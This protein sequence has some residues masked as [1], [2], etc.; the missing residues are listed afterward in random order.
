[1]INTASGEMGHPS[2]C[3]ECT[4]AAMRAIELWFSDN[5]Q[6][7]PATCIAEPEKDEA[8]DPLFDEALQYILMK[9]KASIA[10]IQREFRIG[11]NRAARI[12]E[13]MEELGIVS[14]ANANGNRD[15]LPPGPGN[16]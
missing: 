4:D 9:R 10:G 3:S 6:W 15:V 7:K 2:L 8:L 5:P 12:I 13:Q 16:M 11:F 14:P 1:M